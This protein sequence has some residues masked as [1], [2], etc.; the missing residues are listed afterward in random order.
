MTA[1]QL[2][3]LSIQEK[4]NEIRHYSREEAAEKLDGEWLEA[5]NRYFEK[6]DK[7]M[8]FMMEIKEKVATLIEPP[9]VAKKGIKQRKRD[10]WAKKQAQAAADAAAK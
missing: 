2:E 7:D 4:W 10:A 5:Y 9:K 3:I 1:D 6:F 8:E